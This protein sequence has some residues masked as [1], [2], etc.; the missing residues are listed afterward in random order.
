MTRRGSSLAIGRAPTG[1]AAPGLA[2]LCVALLGLAAVAHPA[3]AQQPA[4][5]LGLGYPV[6][7]LDARAAALG[8]TGVGLLYGSFSLRNPAEITEHRAVAISSSLAPEALTVES[9]GGS[10]STGRTRHSVIRAIVPLQ[11]WSVAVGFGG[12]LDQGWNLVVQDTLDLST[13]RLPFEETREHDGGLSAVDFSLARRLGPLSL[14]VSGQR[15]TGSL[16]QSFTRRF[17]P[18]EDVPD[19]LGGVRAERRLSYGGWRLKAGA[20]VRPT[21][22]VLLGG[23]VSLA[24]ELDVR[25]L[26]GVISPGTSAVGGTELPETA[27]AGSFD[28]PVGFELGGSAHLGRA[29]LLTAAGGWTGWSSVGEVQAGI[30]GR[31]AGWAGAG[32]E[33]HGWRPRGVSVPVRLGGRVAELPFAPEGAEAS[34]ERALTVGVGALFRG[35]LAELGAGFEVGSRGDLAESGLE[36]SF[37]RFTLT[38]SIRQ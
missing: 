27:P 21:G 29:F 20:S 25:E 32:V 8:G 33:I 24:T 7:P 17:E 18:V 12:E 35:G 30:T 9:P 6:P 26:G 38:F 37:R 36:E 19:T 11:E 13:G 23:S 2:V 34:V 28:L 16:R 14:G 31:D 4:T 22:R 1:P 3:A 15:L 5:A 10:S